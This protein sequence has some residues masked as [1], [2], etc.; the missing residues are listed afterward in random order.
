METYHNI[1]RASII[2]RSSPAGNDAMVP[3]YHILS[4][5]MASDFIGNPALVR[6]HEQAILADWCRL[7]HEDGQERSS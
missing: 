6:Q 5:S 1:S 2:A 7:R 4:S 3:E